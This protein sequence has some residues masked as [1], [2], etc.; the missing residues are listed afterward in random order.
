MPARKKNYREGDWFAVPLRSHGFGVGIVARSPKRS[1]VLFGYFF[2]P[3][4]STVPS[5]DEVKEL[6][7]SDAILVDMFGDLELLKGNWT[8]IG[9]QEPWDRTVWPMVDFGRIDEK[10][11]RARRIEYTDD[12]ENDEEREVACSL[13]EAAA[14]PRDRLLGAGAVEIILTQLLGK[15]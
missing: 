14:L 4:R 1:G 12:G 6:R 2:G 5:L 7:P 10:S 9:N 11:G 13:A 8:V 3:A 15:P